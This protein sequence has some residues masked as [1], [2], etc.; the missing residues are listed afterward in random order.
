M[1]KPLFENYIN[2]AMCGVA[3]LKTSN[4]Q[5]YCKACGDVHRWYYVR[6]F[7]ARR[8]A[9]LTVEQRLARNKKALEYYHNYHK[10]YDPKDRRAYW[11]AYQKQRAKLPDNTGVRVVNLSDVQYDYSHRLIKD[12]VAGRKQLAAIGR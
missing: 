8:N 9:N 10:G 2:C 12:I 11:R 1:I 5:K 4:R 6:K 7:L 3:I